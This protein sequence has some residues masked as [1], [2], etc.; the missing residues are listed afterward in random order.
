MLWG[1]IPWRRISL[2]S[3]RLRRG[4]FTVFRHIPLW[5]GSAIR[6]VGQEPPLCPGLVT[7][8]VSG[9]HMSRLHNVQTYIRGRSLHGS[10][11]RMSRDRYIIFSSQRADGGTGEL[12]MW[13]RHPYCFPPEPPSSWPHPDLDSFKASTF[14][15]LNKLVGPTVFYE[16]SSTFLPIRTRVGDVRV[17]PL[18]SD[19]ANLAPLALAPDEWRRYA[20][21][22]R[23]VPPRAPTA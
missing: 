6:T 7:M 17:R 3:G 20:A 21:T 11:S 10:V 15:R 4:K 2:R 16:A 23:P 8:G 14:H 5:R 19:G 18:I 12:F 9:C 13:P 22:A 1:W